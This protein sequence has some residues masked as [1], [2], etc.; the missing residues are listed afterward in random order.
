MRERLHILLIVC[1]LILGSVSSVV[2]VTDHNLKWGFEVGD[3]F[4]YG[5]SGDYSYFGDLELGA[6]DFYVEIDSLP[7]I[8][9]NVT[10]Y[11]EIILSPSYHYT[12]YLEN[13]TEL[14]GLLP[15]GG[16]P[17][18]NWSLIQEFVNSTSELRYQWINTIAEWGIIQIEDDTTMVRT[19]TIKFSKTDGVM[20]LHRVVE[21]PEVGLTIAAQITRKGVQ[22]IPYLY[23]GIG[24]GI[25]VLVLII[26][27]A[28]KRR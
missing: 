20:N 23:V 14:F 19:T 18:G 5:Y 28:V 13:G 7:T 6:F 17:I 22:S 27:V 21:D 26:A 8:P 1:A 16:L 3:Q 25:V 24:V 12:F 10:W 15:W 11:H 2:A 9:N 4:H